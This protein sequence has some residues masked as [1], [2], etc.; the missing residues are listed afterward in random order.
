M[1]FSRGSMPPDPPSLPH[2]LHTDTYLPP[3]E[4]SIQSHFVPLGQKAERYP[5]VHVHYHQC[6]EENIIFK[7]EGE[8]E[9]G[10]QDM[11][12]GTT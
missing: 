2:A 7:L 1:K 6:N 12:V 11:H 5:L 8:K 10:E 4:R 9:E 3:P